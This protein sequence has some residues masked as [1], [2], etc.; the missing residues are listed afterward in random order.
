LNDA[1]VHGIGRFRASPS[2][3]GMKSDVFRAANSTARE[4]VRG[5]HQMLGALGRL[6]WR[7]AGNGDVRDVIAA[8][9]PAS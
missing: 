6:S 5:C 3:I 4:N 2:V 9:E 7:R 8:A 1:R